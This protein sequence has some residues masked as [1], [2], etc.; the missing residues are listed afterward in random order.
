MEALRESMF[1]FHRTFKGGINKTDP[2]HYNFD[3]TL[4]SAVAKAK[5]ANLLTLMK[6]HL[7]EPDLRQEL[8]DITYNDLV[9]NSLA[10]QQHLEAFGAS[11]HRVLGSSLD[12]LIEQNQRWDV[13]SGGIGMPGK[14]VSEMLHHSSIAHSKTDRYVGREDLISSIVDPVFGAPASEEANAAEL[15]LK[16]KGLSL[17]V[18]GASGSG[19]TA[20][21]SKA[22]DAVFA[23]QQLPEFDHVPEIR[24]RPV[25]VHF[26][27]TSADSASAKA[28]MRTIVYQIRLCYGL[29]YEEI[30]DVL[31]FDD[32]KEMLHGLL[33]RYPVVLFVDSLDQLSNDDN[34]RKDIS[35]L[36]GV[37]PHANTRI[38]V[39][40]LPDERAEDDKSWLHFYGCDYTLR[41]EGVPRVTIA[42]VSPT[43][44]LLPS[45]L[46][47]P[48]PL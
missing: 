1:W 43:W 47:S 20:A 22:A 31:R 44:S 13:D 32:V 38:I 9:T 30:S 18:V 5:L 3:D 4:T 8:D 39:S 17:S 45:P 6:Q 34:A 46:S 27:G 48:L 29:P 16:L 2:K 28:L 37:K 42:K 19:K 36:S 33:Q 26:C 24:G 7:P 23:R 41:A 12:A 40:A 11:M 21:M 15:K 35:F 25:L 10:H 14:L